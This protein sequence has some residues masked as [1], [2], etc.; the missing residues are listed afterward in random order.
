MTVAVS[1]IGLFAR[2]CGHQI[3]GEFQYCKSSGIVYDVYAKYDRISQYG[4]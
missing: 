2:L 1:Y 3:Y 4:D